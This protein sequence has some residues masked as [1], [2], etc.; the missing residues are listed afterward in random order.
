MTQKSAL[1][2]AILIFLLSGILAVFKDPLVKTFLPKPRVYELES[3]KLVEGIKQQTGE[4]NPHFSQPI[5]L[6]APAPRPLAVADG[7]KILGA[8]VAAEEKWVEI[9][10]SEQ[11]LYA[12]E[13]DKIVY[14]FLISSGKWA[15]TPKGEFRIWIKLR[16]SSMHGGNKEDGTYYYL[17]NVPYVM[18]FYN[19]YGL[20]GTYW[21]NNFGTP[22]SHGCVNLSIPDAEKLYEWINPVVPA[23]KS[24][25]LP[26]KD[27]PGTR[28]IIH[29]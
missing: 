29:E 25:V 27:T 15:P 20:H 7:E 1:V 19:G 18:Y 13:G 2:S 28:V 14:T 24:V 8:V 22:M 9:D 26:T 17:P 11:K 16:Y 12:H 5:F 23:G 21:H 4:W 3:P 10:L 6:N